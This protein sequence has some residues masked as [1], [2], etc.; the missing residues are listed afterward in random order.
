MIKIVREVAR[1]CYSLGGDM[2]H[3]PK[4]YELIFLYIYIDI[5]RVS[6]RLEI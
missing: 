5:L 6:H 4:S 1:T 3:N 2:C